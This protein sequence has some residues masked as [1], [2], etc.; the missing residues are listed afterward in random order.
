MPISSSTDRQVVTALLRDLDIG[1]RDDGV[2]ITLAE[3]DKNVGGYPG[4]EVIFEFDRS[5]R[6]IQVGAYK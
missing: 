4:Y 3:G 2:Y 5:G 1:F 6:F